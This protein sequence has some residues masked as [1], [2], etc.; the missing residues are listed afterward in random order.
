[1]N[2]F[3]RIARVPGFWRGRAASRRD[4]QSFGPLRAERLFDKD[5]ESV[6]VA[7]RDHVPT[8]HPELAA[9]Y[10]AT[11]D[12]LERDPD[13]PLDLG[14]VVITVRRGERAA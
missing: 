2:E 9:E 12:A 5:G 10:D 4:G 6:N 8:P 13:A 1:M 7:V 3:E 11:A 14:P